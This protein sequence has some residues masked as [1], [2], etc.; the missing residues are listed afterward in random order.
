M[1]ANLQLFL[2]KFIEVNKQKYADEP[3]V[4]ALLEGLTL[5][6]VVFDSIEIDESLG[7]GGRIASF[8]S[9]SRKFNA[10]QQQ[11][12]CS[13]L[14]GK[15]VVTF[16]DA[17]VFDDKASVKALTAPGIYLHKAGDATAV[18]VLTAED[19]ADVD[20]ATQNIIAALTGAVNYELKVEDLL[21]PTFTLG[22]DFEGL[23]SSH[24]I[25]DTFNVYFI[26]KAVAPSEPGEGGEI[27]PGTGGGETGGGETGGEPEVDPNEPVITPEMEAEDKALADPTAGGI[28]S[29]VGDKGFGVLTVPREISEETANIATITGMTFGLV[30]AGSLT[31]ETLN[32]NA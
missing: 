7:E 12:L 27:D 14:Q 6:D 32:E 10:P 17:K 4:L 30:G 22:T 9:P 2:D 31:V 11:W 16:T 18:S 21:I 26:P 25:E 20:T 15:N 13:T 1:D 28:Y 24:C 29:D 5:A 3:E 8:H 19:V 23:V